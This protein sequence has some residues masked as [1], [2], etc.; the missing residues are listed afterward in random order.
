[1]LQVKEV[2]SLKDEQIHGAEAKREV[3]RLKAVVQA[4][5]FTEDRIAELERIIVELTVDRDKEKL[6]K[7]TAVK[8]KTTI[9]KETDL[10]NYYFKNNFSLCNGSKYLAH[11]SILF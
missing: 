8:E 1:M 3:S 5:K 4:T 10:V 11:Y 6:D 7:E 2:T 9:K